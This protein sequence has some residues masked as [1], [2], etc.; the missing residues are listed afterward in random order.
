MEK[1]FG[2]LISTAHPGISTHS[3]PTLRHFAASRPRVGLGGKCGILLLEFGFSTSWTTGRHSGFGVAPA[4]KLLELVPAG[5]AEIFVN[6]H[7]LIMP[8]TPSPQT[9]C[10]DKVGRGPLSR[11]GI[12]SLPAR[13][14]TTPRTPAPPPGPNPIRPLRTTP[15]VSRCVKAT[16]SCSLVLD[17]SPTG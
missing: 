13:E 16:C 2:R 12:P 3:A 17:S 15:Y 8:C 10:I 7:L 9:L 6:R 4:H 14:P 11:G 5:L 1:G